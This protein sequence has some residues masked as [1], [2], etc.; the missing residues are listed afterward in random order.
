MCSLNLGENSWKTGKSIQGMHENEI[1]IH[2]TVNKL[3]IILSPSTIST[4]KKR[5]VFSQINQIAIKWC[6]AQ[7]WLNLRH[8]EI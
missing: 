4:E 7:C 6:E 3:T 5:E 2:Q 8:T 1:V